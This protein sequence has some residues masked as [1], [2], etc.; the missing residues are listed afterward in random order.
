MIE[1]HLV[2]ETIEY[3]REITMDAEQILFLIPKGDLQM[4]MIPACNVIKIIE[5]KTEEQ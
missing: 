5:H 3:A 4:V 2:D 1:Y